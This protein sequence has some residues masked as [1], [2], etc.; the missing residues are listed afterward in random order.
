M[1]AF[2]PYTPVYYSSLGQQQ[3]ENIL[4]PLGVLQTNNTSPQLN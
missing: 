3:L 1:A 2:L 4:G